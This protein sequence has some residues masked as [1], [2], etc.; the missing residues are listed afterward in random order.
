MKLAKKIVE[1]LELNDIRVFEPQKQGKGC[2]YCEIEF[3]SN[4][5]EDCVFTIWYNGKKEDFVDKFFEMVC[6][7]DPDEHAEMWVK[8]WDNVRGVPHSIRTL[9][10]DADSIQEFLIDVVRQ[11]QKVA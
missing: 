9:I 3:S 7:F 2:Y 11:L 4:T 8:N 5:G 1:V 6:E 10:N